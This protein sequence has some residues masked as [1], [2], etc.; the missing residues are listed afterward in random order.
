MIWNPT[1]HVAV[2]AYGFHSVLSGLIGPVVITDV[3][4]I[5][6]GVVRPGGTAADLVGQIQYQST[7]EVRSR[8]AGASVRAHVRDMH[9]YANLSY[10]HGRREGGGRATSQPPVGR[11]RGAAGGEWPNPHRPATH[12]APRG[13]APRGEVGRPATTP[14]PTCGSCAGPASSIR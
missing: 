9:A 1:R 11:R 2:Q 8:G 10:A 5:Q 3:D 14:S 13:G 12:C 6:G 7:G 4:E